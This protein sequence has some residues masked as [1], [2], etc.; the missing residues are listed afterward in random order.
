MTD[1]I[2]LR[3]VI[4]EQG[5]A[6]PEEG[7]D[8][9]RVRGAERQPG[10]LGHPA[11]EDTLAQNRPITEPGGGRPHRD[12]LVHAAAILAAAACGVSPSVKKP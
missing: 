10:A 5:G 3:C 8:I 4:L 1:G 9:D 2:G 11:G 7:D 12:E 6:C